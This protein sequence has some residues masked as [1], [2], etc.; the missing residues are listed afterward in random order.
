MEQINLFAVLVLVEQINLFATSP[1]SWRRAAAVR[2][3]GL[4]P[5]LPCRTAG[6]VAIAGDILHKPLASH[7]PG[8]KSTAAQCPLVPRRIAVLPPLVTL[9]RNSVIVTL[10]GGWEDETSEFFTSVTHKSKPKGTYTH[11]SNNT[12][13]QIVFS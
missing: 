3:L 5:S 4:H 13:K 12:P 8:G 2:R 6:P 9:V 7:E 11:S 1:S 10:C